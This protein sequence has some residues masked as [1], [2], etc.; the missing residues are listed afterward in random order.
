MKNCC[1]STFLRCGF[2]KEFGVLTYAEN[3]LQE[4]IKNHQTT[5]RNGVSW[6]RLWHKV[7]NFMPQQKIN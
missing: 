3:G 2:H 7:F 5:R 1:T 6:Q 4:A